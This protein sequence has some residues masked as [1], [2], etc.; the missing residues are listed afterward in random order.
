VPEIWSPVDGSIHD[1]IVWEKSDKATTVSLPL[2]PTASLFVVFRRPIDKEGPLAVLKHPGDSFF[3]GFKRDGAGIAHLRTSVP[4]DYKFKTASGNILSVRVDE[5]PAPV[6]LDGPWQ[7]SFGP[8]GGAPEKTTMDYLASWTASNV[9]AIKYY[10]GSAVYRKVVTL[11]AG[12][13]KYRQVLDLGAVHNL[14]QVKINGRDLGVWWFPPFA[15]DVTEALHGGEN[16]FEI[17][18]TNTWRN[19]LI[20]DE[21]QVPDLEWGPQRMFRKTIPAGAPLLRFPEWLVQNKPRPSAGRVTFVDWNYF[22]KDSALAEAGLVGP[23]QLVPEA[24]VALSH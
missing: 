22:T 11:P 21:Q 20:G 23:V 6:K 16:E 12:S 13:S 18:V 14:A 5:L 4:G 10:S 1:A 2:G 7:V 9:P 17:T 3:G 15:R 24:E 8:L 19:R